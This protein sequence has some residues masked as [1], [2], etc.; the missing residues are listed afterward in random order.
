MGTSFKTLC[1]VNFG[2]V[3]LAFQALDADGSGTLTLLELRRTC[4]RL[5]WDGDVDLLFEC[6]DVD[7][8]H[9]QN[10]KRTLSF[11]EVEFLDAWENDDDEEVQDAKPEAPAPKII[12]SSSVPS[13]PTLTTSP[14]AKPLLDG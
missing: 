13:L 3:Q 2:S 1:E 8:R 9:D 12:N 5:H 7:R 4:N 11:A 10:D 6:L 14:E